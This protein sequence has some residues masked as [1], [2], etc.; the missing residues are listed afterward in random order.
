MLNEPEQLGLDA[1]AAAGNSGYAIELI[2][3]LAREHRIS[4]IAHV[5]DRYHKGVEINKA[6]VRRFLAQRVP[7]ILSNH[8]FPTLGA[9]R[10][11]RFIKYSLNTAN[12][13]RPVIEA[14]EACA[15]NQLVK[16]VDTIVESI[17]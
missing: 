5:I 4:D 1:A 2:R 7:G 17:S 16:A 11:K 14:A 13:A 8:Y 9:E 15:P 3:F 12:W 6:P 10:F